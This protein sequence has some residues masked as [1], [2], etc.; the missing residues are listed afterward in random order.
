MNIRRLKLCIAA[1]ALPLSFSSVGDEIYKWTDAER[2][3]YE[4]RPSG[5]ASEETLQVTYNRTNNTVVQ[6]RVQSRRDYE[7][8]KVELTASEERKMAE[9]R[10]D[11]QPPAFSR[12]SPT[13][14]R[15]LA[16]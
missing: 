12:S 6:S 2:N 13:P 15:G 16:A 1:C 8:K 5:G 4:D 11:D 9:Q 10:A 3:H 14:D 7:A